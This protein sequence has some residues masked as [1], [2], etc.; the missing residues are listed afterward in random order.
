MHTKAHTCWPLWW[1]YQLKLEWWIFLKMIIFF[2]WKTIVPII[3]P[4]TTN[5]YPL[6]YIYGYGCQVQVLQEA[7]SDW[8]IGITVLFSW[9]PPP[10]QIKTL[11]MYVSTTAVLSPSS[12]HT[13]I[14]FLLAAHHFQE[15][16]I[17]SWDSIFNFTVHTV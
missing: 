16:I 1:C 13:L 15:E 7:K 3:V 9:H 12:L 10:F 17:F 5:Y 6:V 2:F 11:T 14:P 4:I 8:L